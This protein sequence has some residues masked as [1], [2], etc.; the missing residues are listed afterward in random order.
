M[1]VLKHAKTGIDYGVSFSKDGITYK[2]SD[3]GKQFAFKALNQVLSPASIAEET[4]KTVIKGI[5]LGI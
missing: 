5:S 3:I 2:G 1:Q 4:A